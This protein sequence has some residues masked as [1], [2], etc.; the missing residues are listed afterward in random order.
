MVVRTN[1]DG[2]VT[3]LS[4][5]KVK[6]QGAK[7]RRKIKKAM[8]K[9]EEA[10]R[11]LA[12]QVAQNQVMNEQLQDQQEKYTVL[13]QDH[14]ILEK[15]C[16][17]EA[18]L[19]DLLQKKLKGLKELRARLENDLNDETKNS[20]EKDKEI[21]RLG[22]ER[23]EVLRE[24][25]KVEAQIGIEKEGTAV[26]KE[27]LQEQQDENERLQGNIAVEMEDNDDLRYVLRKER[28]NFQDLLK[29]LKFNRSWRLEKTE[30]QK[31]LEVEEEMV[32]ELLGKLAKRGPKGRGHQ[33]GIGKQMDLH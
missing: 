14:E 5:G 13:A 21:A 7:D 16:V 19:T 30:L 8:K 22:R 12:E 18:K 4:R 33:S 29:D 26:V 15:K 10:E 2:T 24:L 23:Q 17:N 25:Q 27:K 20:A 31:K 6:T 9:R 32:Q 3:F 28:T 1:P 11:K